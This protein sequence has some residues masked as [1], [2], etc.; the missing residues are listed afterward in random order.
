MSFSLSDNGIAAEERDRFST[1][2]HCIVSLQN[3]EA[4]G[5]FLFSPLSITNISLN[6]VDHGSASVSEV[7]LP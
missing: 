2:L 1:I 6:T 3:L 4:T 7:E 5:I